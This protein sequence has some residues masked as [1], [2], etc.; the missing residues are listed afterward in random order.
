MVAT[1]AAADLERAA[2]GAVPEQLAAVEVMRGQQL[3]PPHDS[4]AM[5]Q[6]RGQEFKFV[7][8]LQ[9]GVRLDQE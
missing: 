9:P 2:P 1:A 8:S 5:R 7:R 6:F 3:R 4:V